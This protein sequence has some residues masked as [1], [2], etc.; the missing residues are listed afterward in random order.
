MKKT[1]RLSAT[2][3]S[4]ALVRQNAYDRFHDQLMSGHI[5]PGQMLSQ[6]ELV[7]M[8]NVSLGALRELLPKL[9]AE[10][11]ISVQPQ[12]G[13]LVTSI[14]L[15]MIRNAYQ[16]RLA[17]EREAVIAAVANTENDEAVNEQIEI[18]ENILERVDREWTDDILT[19]AQ[20]IDSGMHVFLIGETGNELIIQAYNINA[21][22]VR[23]INIDR[24]RLTVNNIHSAFGDHLRILRAICNRDRGAAIC[25]MEEHV[26]KA[27][28]RAVEL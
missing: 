24:Q 19:E 2:R 11:L 13:I 4:G 22:R 26:G 18:H 7:D 12:R 10:G 17:L 6:R 27:R 8:L 14:D 1:S 9:E 20:S 28:A 15:R 21:I 3:E 5:R 23:L 16:L 25:A